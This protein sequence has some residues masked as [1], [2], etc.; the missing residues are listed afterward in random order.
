MD[1]E[2]EGGLMHSN[3]RSSLMR[4]LIFTASSLFIMREH[5]RNPTIKPKKDGLILSW[6]L[7][8]HAQCIQ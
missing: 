7:A 1:F 6:K 2:Y 5:L 8:K 3:A 4:A